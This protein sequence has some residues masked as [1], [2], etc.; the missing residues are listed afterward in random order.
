MNDNITI[1]I[2][3]Y[4]NENTIERCVSSIEKQ[5]TNK[6]EIIVIDDCS[7]DKS[8]YILESRYK[9]NPCI[10]IRKN[11]ENRGVS[12]TRNIGIELSENKFI[13]FLD[14]D[15]YALDGYI[16]YIKNNIN[17]E[18]LVVFGFTYVNMLTNNCYKILPN[19]KK[20]ITNKQLIKRELL[21][22]DCDEL[23]SSCCNKVYKKDI[24][25]TNYICFNDKAKV[26]EDFEFNIEY[27]KHIGSLKVETE[28]FYNYTYRGDISASSTYK[29]S[30]Y[31]R[32]KE[33][34][35]IRK[36]FF[37]NYYKEKIDKLNISLLL[38]CVNNLYKKKC[39]LSKSQRREQLKQIIKSEYFE[40]WLNCNIKVGIM[41]KILYICMISRNYIISDICLS[42]L[43]FM[44]RH[45]TILRKI[46]M[47]MNRKSYENKEII[48]DKDELISVIIPVY[49][50]EKYI[51]KCVDSVISQTYKN[52]EIILVDDGSTD[53]SSIICD[54]YK[55]IDDRII[56]VHKKNGGLSDARNVG[57]ENSKGQYICFIDSDDYIASNFIYELYQTLKITNSDISICKYIEVYEGQVNIPIKN[58][59]RIKIY[60]GNKKIENLYNNNDVVTVVAWNKL[61]KKYI[62]ENLRYPVGMLHEDEFIIFDILNIAKRVS[63]TSLP[64]YYYLKR[65]DSI[66]GKYKIKRVVVLRALYERLNKCKSIGNKK[67][68]GLTLCKYYSE[69][70]YQYIMIKNC[71][72][73]K[74]EILIKLKD[75][76]VKLKKDFIGNIYISIIDKLKVLIKLKMYNI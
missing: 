62:F 44:K 60:D 5:I 41:Q 76:L 47:N 27:A 2:S 31:E 16:E 58:K 13:I 67:I 7:L 29:D 49:N 18:D 55:E 50:V 3:C 26:M 69:L 51:N 36:E 53:N 19:R 4:N 71:Y 54:E 8:F 75:E 35:N 72:Q 66:T 10:K 38:L 46:F 28:S 12:Y 42:M 64:C 25:S 30:L 74:D 61:Y 37:G 1:I 39:D 68:Y 9:N 48:Y 14:G 34:V 33:I 15:D 40:M 17:D 73:N 56:V 65:G 6:D 63:Y 23:L 57:I 45:S 32:F 20:I 70:L 21:Y 24:I 52:I 43:H 11:N 59:R 22:L